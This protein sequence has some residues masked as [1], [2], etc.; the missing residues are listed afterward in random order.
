MRFKKIKESSVHHN[1][2][3]GI[4]DREYELPNGETHHFFVREEPDTCCVLAR[5]SDGKYV[6]I[7]QFRVGPEE[8]L[9]EIP[10]GRVEP[11]D[12]DVIKR[13]EQELKEETGY[14]GDMKKV[15]VIPG[16][17]YTTRS[18]H[19]FV[20]DHCERVG[21][22]ELDDSEFIEVVLLEESEMRAVLCE[23]KSSSCGPGLLAW[24]HLHS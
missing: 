14:A 7:R 11:G 13:M 1:P 2:Y 16:G 19:V 5:T 15:G 9:H 21:E 20:A 12:T 6:S 22:Q 18:I 8:I 17:P 3:F 10:G 4:L 24:S 23:G